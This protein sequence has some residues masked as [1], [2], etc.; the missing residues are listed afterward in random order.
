[1]FR[2]YPL[3]T[4][5]EEP[6]INM[7]VDWKRDIKILKFENGE[8]LSSNNI[9][10]KNPMDTCIKIE[11]NSRDDG[12][13]KFLIRQIKRREH[14]FKTK[15]YRR[16]KKRFILKVKKNALKPAHK[17]DKF[18]KV[19]YKAI[20][21]SLLEVAKLQI[22][23][24]LRYRHLGDGIDHRREICFGAPEHF[25]QFIEGIYGRER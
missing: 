3:R 17:K 6:E 14:I 22:A 7:D 24:Y 13:A 20:S 21:S 10:P 16:F 15:K 5:W 18:L 8:T 23:N 2:N 1:M 9:M 4:E 19:L 12:I 25:K 11:Y